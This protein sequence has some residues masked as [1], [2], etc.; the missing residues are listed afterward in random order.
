[1]CCSTTK[2]LLAEDKEVSNQDIGNITSAGVSLLVEL[3]SVG[4]RFVHINANK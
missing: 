4:P 1:M 2:L 3:H